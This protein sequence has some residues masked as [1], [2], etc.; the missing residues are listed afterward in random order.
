MSILNQ[1]NNHILGFVSF[2]DL[3]KQLF[4]YDQ[5]RM[6]K[7][8]TITTI[9]TLIILFIP[10][11]EQYVW[12][13]FWTLGL[14]YLVLTLDFITAIAVTWSEKK[15]VTAKA[16]RF[17]VSAPAYFIL[18]AILHSFGKVIEAFEMTDV[19]NP[20]AFRFLAI[21]TY[22]LCITINLLSSLKHMSKLELIPPSIAKFI[23]KFIDIHKNKLETISDN[24]GE[25]E[26][27]TEAPSKSEGL[28][29]DTLF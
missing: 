13:P 5:I 7:L 2:S 25:V 16:M 11:L 8:L 19:F 23:T 20:I 10:F 12:S 6:H 18:F 9:M 4:K 21:A 27:P 1:K 3:L 29:D 14:F 22:F 17:V 28:K 26:N 15:F 24:G